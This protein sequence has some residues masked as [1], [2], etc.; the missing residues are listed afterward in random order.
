MKAGILK[1]ILSL[2]KL[3]KKFVCGESKTKNRKWKGT[4]AVFM[5][6]LQNGQS[7]YY[8]KEI[9]SVGQDL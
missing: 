3:K 6:V 8:N 7:V 1:A 5:F 2:C 4:K 9:R